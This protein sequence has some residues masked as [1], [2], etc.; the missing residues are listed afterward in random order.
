[1]NKPNNYQHYE[2]DLDGNFYR[3]D[4]RDVKDWYFNI[5]K[6]ISDVII[7]IRSKIIQ[8]LYI[9]WNR[10]Y[11]TFNGIKYN[12]QISCSEDEYNYYAELREKLFNLGCT[13]IVFD[14]GVLD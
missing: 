14:Y 5:N 1:M 2:L 12:E 9:K 10:L 6:D 11:F 7:S 13:D 3:F 4:D 8:R